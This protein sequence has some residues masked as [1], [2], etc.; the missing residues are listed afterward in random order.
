MKGR[1]F[2][3]TREQNAEITEMRKQNAKSV[4]KKVLTGMIYI[5]MVG[6]IAYTLLFL[7]MI[8]M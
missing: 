2:V 4:L 5:F 8:I 3:Q 6:V 7:V 1:I